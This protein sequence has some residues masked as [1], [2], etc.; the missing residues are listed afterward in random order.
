M[1]MIQKAEQMQQVSRARR[2]RGKMKLMHRM[3]PPSHHLDDLPHHKSPGAV[4]DLC[5]FSGLGISQLCAIEAGLPPNDEHW[6]MEVDPECN[7]I[8]KKRW[9]K[10]KNFGSIDAFAETAVVDIYKAQT[11]A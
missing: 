10:A 8:L 6:L 5:M 1:L 4:I 7:K 2:G 11:L 9:P 3:S